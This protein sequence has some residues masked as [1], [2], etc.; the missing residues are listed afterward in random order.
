MDDLFEI[1]HNRFSGVSEILRFEKEAS[2]IGFKTP[3]RETRSQRP[4]QTTLVRAIP[5]ADELVKETVFPR[6][7][8]GE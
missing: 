1:A 4:E 5:E 3:S 6:D 2:K 8:E 7:W